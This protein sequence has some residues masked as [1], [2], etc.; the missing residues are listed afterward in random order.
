MMQFVKTV[1]KF[2]IWSS[3]G[4]KLHLIPPTISYKIEFHHHSDVSRTLC[5]G[6]SIYSIDRFCVSYDERIERVSPIQITRPHI[7]LFSAPFPSI[8][9]FV[10]SF[11][12]FPRFVYGCSRLFLVCTWLP[13]WHRYEAQ[14]FGKFHTVF[15]SLIS[16]PI[17]ITSLLRI[18]RYYNIFPSRREML[19][20]FHILPAFFLSL[21]PHRLMAPTIIRVCLSVWK[22]IRW[23]NKRREPLRR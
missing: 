10:S 3:S 19:L 13:S 17:L 21:S 9:P 14:H 20:L 22:F 15:S 7:R 6:S 4:I 1:L 16:I 2:P 8:W 18:R 11:H 23:Q 12:C 5:T